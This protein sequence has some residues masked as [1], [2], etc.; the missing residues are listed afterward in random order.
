[1][2]LFIS[3]L[4][5]DS[6]F[7]LMLKDVFAENDIECFVDTSNIAPGEAWEA[8]IRG[9]IECCDCFLPCFSEHYAL[10]SSTYMNREIEIAIESRR[11]IFPALLS[12]GMPNLP[13]TVNP[14][15][16]ALNWISLS[17]D[18]WLLSVGRLTAAIT[19]GRTVRG[20]GLT[21]LARQ[22]STA[23][24]H[25][26]G[27][28]LQNLKG[29]FDLPGSLDLLEQGLLDPEEFVR[30]QALSLIPVIG[31]A[32]AT[33]AARI[34]LNPSADTTLQLMLIA[35]LS[36][37]SKAP[38]VVP[39]M[40]QL[41]QARLSRHSDVDERNR[42]MD[43]ALTALMIRELARV[44]EPAELIREGLIGIQSSV[45]EIRNAVQDALAQ[46]QRS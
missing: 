31:D 15:L 4:R 7:V 21:Q 25:E 46:L 8:K 33:V 29:M 17:R 11:R 2:D 5:E 28:I 36:C 27:E 30:H 20:A 24:A 12:G 35:A 34:F 26:K 38:Q 1:M 14:A 22:F 16:Q 23:G 13:G 41:I 18:T 43:D 9:E 42:L 39:A 10:K 44:G 40:L 45:F 3:Y 37:T 19:R 6:E 32:G